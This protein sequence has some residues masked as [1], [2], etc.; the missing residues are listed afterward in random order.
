VAR[1]YLSSLLYVLRH[2]DKA[3]RQYRAA[4]DQVADSRG[5]P[6]SHSSTIAE[7]RAGR[8]LI[9]IDRAFA[10]RVL[11]RSSPRVFE[12]D[13]GVSIAADRTVVRALEVISLVGLVSNV[14]LAPLVWGWWALV[15]VPLIVVCWI[16]YGSWASTQAGTV[17]RAVAAFGLCLAVAVQLTEVPTTL[18]LWVASLGTVVLTERMVYFLSSRAVRSIAAQSPRFFAEFLG[19]RRILEGAET[20]TCRSFSWPPNGGWTR[21]RPRA[22]RA[23]T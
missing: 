18:R 5:I 9:G 17:W 20:L 13:F 2:H 6:P 19:A 14:V 3:S 21:R 11:T 22:E 4:L 12:R 1:S 15:V 16:S 7:A 10:R 23:D 8:V